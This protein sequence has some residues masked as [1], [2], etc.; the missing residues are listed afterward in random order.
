MLELT[1]KFIERKLMIIYLDQNKWIDLA[2]A[3]NKPEEYPKYVKTANLV[4]EKAKSG[5]W[6]FPL[7][8]IHVFETIS[9]ADPKSRKKL[10]DIMIEVSNGYSIKSFLDVQKEEFVNAFLNIYAPEKTTQIDAIIKNPLVA[11]GAEE[12]SIDFKIPTPLTIKQEIKSFIN[13]TITNDL[14]I[15]NIILNQYDKKFVNGLNN[16]DDISIDKMGRDRDSLLK[17][18]KENRYIIFLSDRFSALKKH[19]HIDEKILVETNLLQKSPLDDKDKIMKLLEGP[20]PSFYV[21]TKLTYHLLID[22]ERPI[23][24]HDNRDID[25]LST[26][27]PY[28]DVVIT[29]KTW[30]HSSNINKLNSKYSTIIESD[31][32][33]LLKLVE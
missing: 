20:P 3:I 23:Q 29:E 25:F 9:R 22:K 5:D 13:D 33:Y 16:D 19:L 31:L 28:C 2:K 4:L 17:L 32:N 26:A 8:I 7:S 14:S 30:K 6:I 15:R 1:V 27:I 12:I 11:I 18:P 10:V 21:G 24:K